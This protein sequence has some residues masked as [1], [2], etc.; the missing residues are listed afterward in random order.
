M[1]AYTVEVTVEEGLEAQVAAASLDVA[2]V[3]RAV[4]AVLQAEATPGPLEVG[5]LIADDARLQTLNRTYRGLD[6]PTDVLAFADDGAV[7]PFVGQPA[8]PRYLGD[9]ALSYQRVIAQAAEYGHSPARELAFLAVHGTLHLLGYDHERSPA[10][11]ATMRAREEVA[12]A[13]LPL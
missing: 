8:A 12:L 7:S 9:I 5:V 11:A 4:V 13:G 10:D 6:A 3:E 1:T 2:L